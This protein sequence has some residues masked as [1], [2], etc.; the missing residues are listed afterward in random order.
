MLK[1]LKTCITINQNRYES[2]TF[3]FTKYL[4]KSYFYSQFKMFLKSKLN[5]LNISH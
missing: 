4:Q 5:R 2:K 1:N 3:T